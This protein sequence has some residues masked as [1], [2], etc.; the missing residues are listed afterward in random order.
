MTK[1]YASFN[2]EISPAPIAGFYDSS[3]NPDLDYTKGFIEITEEQ[4]K[5]RD[6]GLFAVTN[7]V[8]GPYTPP[9]V[10]ISLQ[11]QARTEQAWVIQQASL[12]LA[13]GETFTDDMKSYA[14]AIMAIATGADTTS[15]ALPPR[16]TGSPLSASKG[17]SGGEVAAS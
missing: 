10:V 6:A 15:T 5:N 8:F 3:M 1:Y 17:S 14:R 16:P 7:G 13:M 2:P 4:Y 9:P 11:S 12:A